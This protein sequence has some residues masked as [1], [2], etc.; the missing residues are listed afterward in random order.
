MMAKALASAQPVKVALTN[1]RKDGTG[2]QL[3]Y[4]KV[5]SDY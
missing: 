3:K 5:S 2:K 1:R 4:V